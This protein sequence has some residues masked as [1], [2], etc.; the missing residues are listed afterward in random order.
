MS[1]LPILVRNPALGSQ[2]AP[3]NTVRVLCFVLVVVVGGDAPKCD[4][5]EPRAASASLARGMNEVLHPNA[6]PPYFAVRYEASEQKGELA[7]PV[8]Y[9]VWIPPG[10]RSLRGVIVHQH[11]CGAGTSGESAAYDSHWQALARKWDCALLGP[12]YRKETENML[13]PL[14]MDPRRG[15]ERAFLRALSEL[16]AMAGHPELSRVP[17][18]LWGHSGGGIWASTMHLLHPDRVVAVWM[19]SGSSMTNWGEEVGPKPPI[20]TGTWDVPLALNV[21]QKETA[22]AD[23]S[24]KK[25]RRIFEAYRQQDALI[26]W[27]VDPLTGHECGNSRYVAI[28]FLDACLEQRLP[29]PG[30]SSQRLRP[31][32]PGRAWSSGTSGDTAAPLAV[33]SKLGS[34]AS[35]LPDAKSALAWMHFVRTGLLQDSTPPPA[36]NAVRLGADGVL[37]WQADADLESGLAGFIIERDGKEIAR[38]PEQPSRSS[39]TPIWQGLTSGDTPVRREPGFRYRDPAGEFPAHRYGIRAVN[40]AGLASE[41]VPGR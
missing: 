39:G 40:A 14:W 17:W 31:I 35:W 27:V 7:M 2:A 4:A 20:K 5:A 23:S 37:H 26:A 18:A 36:P 8:I 12:S 24:G 38:L 15:S 10:V 34:F 3:W 22:L 19:R 13:C 29:V 33:S 9:T 6:I 21:G 11:G 1:N 28:P 41:V 16:G 25:W 30:D 32:A